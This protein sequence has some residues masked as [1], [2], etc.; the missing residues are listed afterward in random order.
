MD[1]G[2]LSSRPAADVLRDARSRLSA[3]R[4]TF[5]ELAEREFNDAAHYYQLE[6][7]GLG[8]AFIID[9]SRCTEAIAA[10]PATGAIIGAAIRR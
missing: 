2:T 10:H 3:V 7:P 4:V 8:D 6:Q 1:A 9:V 5:N